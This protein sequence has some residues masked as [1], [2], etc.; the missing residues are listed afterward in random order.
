M[1]PVYFI[2]VGPIGI[3]SGLT[4]TISMPNTQTEVEYLWKTRNGSIYLYAVGSSGGSGASIVTT[5]VRKK[6]VVIDDSDFARDL[7]TMRLSRTCDLIYKGSVII[8]IDAAC[9]YN[10]DLNK[11]IFGLNIV[12]IEYDFASWTCTLTVQTERAYARSV[13]IKERPPTQQIFAD[14]ISYNG[15]LGAPIEWA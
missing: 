13:S 6:I 1:Q 11:K 4:E 2:T 9:F 8:T 7:V 3:E 15:I 10:V 5:E 12:G 14:G